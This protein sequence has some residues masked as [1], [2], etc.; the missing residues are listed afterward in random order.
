MGLSVLQFGLDQYLDLS[1][2]KGQS[3]ALAILFQRPLGFHALFKA[4]VHGG[5]HIYILLC[6]LLCPLRASI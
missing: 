5:A 4:F 2:I 1:T 6:D 3:S